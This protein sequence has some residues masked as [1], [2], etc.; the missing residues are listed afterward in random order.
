[1][2][3]LGWSE[4]SSSSSSRT[5]VSGLWWFCSQFPS[6]NRSMWLTAVMRRAV[7]SHKCTNNKIYSVC[8]PARALNRSE[9]SCDKTV[10]A[11][12]EDL[13]KFLSWTL[14]TSGSPSLMLT[15]A[16]FFFPFLFL[17]LSHAD[18]R[19]RHHGKKWHCWTYQRQSSRCAAGI[20][21]FWWYF[22]FIAD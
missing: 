2:D 10:T 6:A 17:I 22:L 16:K 19:S 18:W 7:V 12:R 14:K 4:S 21:I 15:A 11:H 13:I 20:L 1:M 9:S 3:V 8:S 5:L